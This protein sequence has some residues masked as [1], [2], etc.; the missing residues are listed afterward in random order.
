MSS[1]GIEI[2]LTE[3]RVQAL[4]RRLFEALGVE[5][6]RKRIVVVKSGQHFY[7]SFRAVSED[8]RYL[9]E[10]GLLQDCRS[11]PFRKIS[12]PRWPLDES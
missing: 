6:A 9:R 3:K 2:V 12:R 8:V 7:A 1:E 11:L 5:L 10:R 4:D